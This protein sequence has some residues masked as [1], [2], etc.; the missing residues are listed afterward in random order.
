MKQQ[1]EGKA[2]QMARKYG[3]DYDNI[4]WL[5]LSKWVVLIYALLSMFVMFQRA[6]MINITVCACALYVLEN[7]QYI[8]RQ[9]FRG[10][11]LMIFV[12]WVYDFLYLFWFSSDE[13]EDEEGGGM[14]YTVTRFSRLFAYIN[15]VFKVIVF[16][17]FWK[18]SMDFNSIV[19]KNNPLEG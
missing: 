19:R 1:L 10:F 6:G 8:S 18:D 16:L 12:T 14:E 11:V 15:L 7:P 4:M 17:V 3:V 9:T 13:G 5:D 2:S